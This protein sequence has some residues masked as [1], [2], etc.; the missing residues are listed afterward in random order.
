M[1]A[2]APFRHDATSPKGAVDTEETTPSTTEIARLPERVTDQIR[3]LRRIQHKRSKKNNDRKNEKKSQ[4]EKEEEQRKRQRRREERKRKEREERQE[5]RRREKR[6]RQQEKKRRKK[7]GGTRKVVVDDEELEEA[8]WKLLESHWGDYLN[9]EGNSECSNEIEHC[10]PKCLVF[11]KTNSYIC[12]C[13]STH[14][15]NMEDHRCS[16]K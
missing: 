11:V 15:L 7:E 6:K 10:R 14:V 4:E 5:K 12:T 1:E 9:N 13:P 3:S 16:R 8:L 2:S